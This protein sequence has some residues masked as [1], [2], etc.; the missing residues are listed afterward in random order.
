MDEGQMLNK[1]QEMLA[2]KPE[3]F[4]IVEEQID[5][6]V[7]LEYFKLSQELKNDDTVSANV[8]DKVLLTDPDVTLE[9]K[10]K[11]L[12][13]LASTDDVASYRCIEEYAKNPDPELKDWTALA[14]RESKLMLES[15]LLDER[16]ILISTGLGGR[17]K[18][19]RYFVVLINNEKLEFSDTQKKLIKNEVEF[20]LKN[21]EGELESV[22][23]EKYYGILML[24]LPLSSSL[25]S[26]LESAVDECNQ[27]GDF[28]MSNF[29]V[30]NVKK[31][32]VEEI[33]E[34]LEKAENES[35]EDGDSEGADDE[36]SSGDK[37][38]DN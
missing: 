23:F 18:S 30:T 34:F 17:G 33:D 2:K 14:L 5:V 26:V 28:L 10:K 31:L 29:L 22:I 35:E 20:A 37:D 8:D 21:N 24:L 16:Q 9:E 7:Q 19:L 38:S 6:E 1:I 13:Q 36:I 12:N 11:Y 25:R 15:S 3:Q 32:S 4:A 27:Y